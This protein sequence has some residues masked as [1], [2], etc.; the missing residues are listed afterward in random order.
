MVDDGRFA[1]LEAPHHGHDHFG[2][3]YGSREEQ[4]E[5]VVP[6]LRR[7]LDR[8]ERVVYAVADRTPVEISAALRAAG[9]DVEE[10]RE[11]GALTFR[12]AAEIYLHDGE[13]DPERAVDRVQAL[14]DGA[15]EEYE[16]LRVAA[17]MTG[18]LLERIDPENVLAYE[19]EIDRL[20]EG[21]DLIG[22]CQYD[23][24]SIPRPFLEAVLES[25]PRLAYD[26]VVGSNTYYTDPAADEADVDTDE[27][28]EDADD[29]DSEL[30]SK[31]EAHRQRV[32]AERSL[33]RRESAIATL[34][35]ATEEVLWADPDAVPEIVAESTR[36]A[37]DC[38]H[39]SLWL[40][41]RGSDALECRSV[42][43]GAADGPSAD[44]QAFEDLAWET[45]VTNDEQR[46]SVDGRSDA[47]TDS[48][49]TGP[50]S[51]AVALPLA[52]TGALVAATSTADRVDR[53]RV[54]IGRALASVASVAFEKARQERRIEDL[55]EE[56][57]RLATVETLVRDLVCEA[58]DASSRR[59][60]ERALCETLAEI[61]DVAFVWAGAVD[62]D[63]ETA[64]PHTWAGEER[65]YLSATV[66][67]GRL[68]SPVVEA[69]SST[70][71]TVVPQIADAYAEE[72]WSRAALDRGFRAVASVPLCH[73]QLTYGAVTVYASRPAAFTEVLEGVL[74]DVGK[75]AGYLLNVVERDVSLRSSEPRE[76]ELELSA[77]AFPFVELAAELECHLEVDD[78]VSHGDHGVVAVASLPADASDR[79]GG[80]AEATD[81]I[82][83]A[84]V[85]EESDDGVLL[86]LSLADE[87]VGATLSARGA[88]ITSLTADPESARIV[89]E[90]PEAVGE[91]TVVDAVAE[92]Y[93]RP[94]LL[95]TRGVDAAT[96]LGTSRATVGTQFTDRQRQVA[97]VAYH[98]GYFDSP[99]RCT[100]EEVADVLGISPQAFYQHLRRMER[101]LFD[102]VVT[103]S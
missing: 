22:L 85:V 51:A 79:V 13:F 91:R 93:D 102:Q 19:A 4:L 23:R 64:T 73:E 36:S 58:G 81:A 52:G 8:G 35:C 61:D 37:L 75:F 15:S 74:E 54:E 30:R 83:R 34:A 9:V 77:P 17:E 63:D 80:A 57:T 98:A 44:V 24:S 67:D 43:T 39:A 28:D 31:L 89:V 53:D 72:Q 68:P 99:R 25:H 76:V 86:D 42:S 3:L 14:A 60:V 71:P 65:D 69:V 16:R 20:F 27:G 1:E 40:Y 45:F 87:F 48:A 103:G 41:D 90:T 84:E 47:A 82:E 18:S 32:T 38:E 12:D 10:A 56:R 62:P 5:V 55:R 101:T 6:F 26:G 95:A 11:S 96:P 2:F 21:V 59:D 70:E 46:W 97:A 100:G 66:A 33:R 92:Q 29:A 50:L 78:V 88:A 94:T 49:G 7:G